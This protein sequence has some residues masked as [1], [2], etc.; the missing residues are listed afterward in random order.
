MFNGKIHYKWA[1]FN[2][3]V[4]NYQRVTF[5]LSSCSQRDAFGLRVQ[6]LRSPCRLPAMGV[7]APQRGQW[8]G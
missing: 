1:I 5:Q 7:Q 4:T 8:C 6:R 2:S 3:Y